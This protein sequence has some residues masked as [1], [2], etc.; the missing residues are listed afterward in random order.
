MET[1]RIA[2]NVLTRLW[3]SYRKE[4]PDAER[5]P[6]SLI[7]KAKGIEQDKGKGEKPESKKPESKSKDD[8]VKNAPD[9]KLEDRAKKVMQESGFSGIDDITKTM[10]TMLASRS[11]LSKTDREAPAGKHHL[12]RLNALNVAMAAGDKYNAVFKKVIE[13]DGDLK[14]PKV[15]AEMAKHIKSTLDALDKFNALG[16][17]PPKG[18]TEK[19]KGLLSGVKGMA[20][21]LKSRIQGKKAMVALMSRPAGRTASVSDALVRKMIRMA[22]ADPNIRAHLLPIIVE[23]LAG[24]AE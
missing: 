20:D 19:I 11:T 18:M 6:K 14:D 16:D 3:N 9:K 1:P 2:D 22:H 23:H 10:D 13:E 8:E 4:H 5:P 12:K 21:K 24:S 15:K 7:E 17:A